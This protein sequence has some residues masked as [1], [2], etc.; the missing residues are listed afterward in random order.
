MSEVMHAHHCTFDGPD[1]D[2]QPFA[3]S[4]FYGR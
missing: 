1:P 4:Q 3:V 2:R